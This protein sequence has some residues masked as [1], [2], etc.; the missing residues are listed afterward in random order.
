[1]F[2]L[3]RSEVVFWYSCCKTDVMA[4]CIID[5]TTKKRQLKLVLRNKNK[6]QCQCYK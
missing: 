4:K 2:T 1:M 5:F 6:K 3:L